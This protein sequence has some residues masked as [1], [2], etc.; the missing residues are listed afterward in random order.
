L[1]VYQALLAAATAAEDTL[2]IYFSG[3]GRTGDR[4]ELFLCLPNTDPDVLSFTALPYYE[5]GKAVAEARV[6]K[7]VVILDCCFSGRA[8]PDQAGDEERIVGQVGIEGSYILTATPANAVALAPPGERYTAFTGALLDLLRA[9]IPGGRELLTFAEIY[10]QLR[11]TLTS[12]RLPKPRQ[13]GSD[14]ITGLAIARNAAFTRLGPRPSTGSSARI[15]IGESA[16]EA[17][18][19][20]RYDRTRVFNERFATAAGQLGSDK[21]PEVRLAGVYAMAGLADGWEENRQTCVDVLCGCLRMPYEPDPGA[22]APR[23]ERLA[24]RASRE[25]RH[26]VIRVITAHLKDGAAVSWQG[27]NFDFTGVVFDGGD[28]A[29]ARFSGGTVSFR[30][31]VFSS[32]KIRFTNAEFS[33]GE[34]NFD[35]AVFSAEAV[36]FDFAKFVG[37]RVSFRSATFSR[38][39]VSFYAAAFCGGTVDFRRAEF[40]GGQVEFTDAGFSGGTV[41]FAD[42]RFS[43]GEVGFADAEFSGGTVDFGDARDWS[44]P[45]M[46]SWDGEP[47][48]GVVLPVEPSEERRDNL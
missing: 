47:P 2:L 14:T 46:F 28:F 8:I 45:P 37:G 12:R 34:V 10:P 24:F 44:D 48:T 43:G 6:T 7:K 29:E 39:A 32:G 5:L 11:Y 9:G 31:A 22:E 16:Q 13:R 41:S 33:G 35:G 1:D 38:G 20:V 3:H 30:D 42:A 18:E 26:T 36:D 4:N 17:P 25:V 19:S 23:S 21:P 27:L 15:V 40:S